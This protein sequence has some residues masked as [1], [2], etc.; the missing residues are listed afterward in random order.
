MLVGR[1]APCLHGVVA[2][3]LLLALTLTVF[4][5]LLVVLAGLERL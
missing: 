2:D 3:L 5:A 4:G 1:D